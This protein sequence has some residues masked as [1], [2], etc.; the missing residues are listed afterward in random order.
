MLH[1]FLAFLIARE[2]RPTLRIPVALVAATLIFLI[3]FS[4]LY[5]GAH[6]LSDV[7]GAWAFGSA[8]LALLGLSYIRRQ[9]ERI[10]PGSLLAVGCVALVRRRIQYLSE[11]A[12]QRTLRHQE[13]GADDGRH[14]LVGFG[15]AA[16][17]SAAHRSYR[18][19]GRAAGVPV[20]W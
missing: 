18:R 15:L 3:A 12:M 11:H 7:V 14:R 10:D 2:T 19:D 6:W 4:R 8:W 20:G 9:S 13:C 16:A 5:L 1:G 17:A